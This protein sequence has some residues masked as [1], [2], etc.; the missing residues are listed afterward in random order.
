MLDWS[1][2]DF[3]VR[4]VM[5]LSHQTIYPP[6]GRDNPVATNQIYADHDLDAGLT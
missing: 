2:E 1:K 5:R 4:P 6:P 3:G